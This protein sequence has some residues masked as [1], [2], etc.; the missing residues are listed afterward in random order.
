[1]A[2]I[3]QRGL[4]ADAIGSIRLFWVSSN[5]EFTNRITNHFSEKYNDARFI[6][7][8]RN[9]RG[10]LYGDDDFEVSKEDPY[11]EMLFRDCMEE[12]DHFLGRRFGD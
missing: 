7:C 11:E 9:I 5:K 3:L 12:I 1:M 6:N 10:R 4:T 8:L 2:L